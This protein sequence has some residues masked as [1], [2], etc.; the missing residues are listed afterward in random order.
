M[1]TSA[2]R[3]FV[4]WMAFA[5]GLSVASATPVYA[6][7]PN[8]S[9]AE[10]FA[11]SCALEQP[12]RTGFLL[13]TL[14]VPVRG[15]AARIAVTS[16]ALRGIE[17]LKASRAA[18][19]NQANSTSQKGWFER[20]WKWVVIPAAAVVATWLILEAWGCTGC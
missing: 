5:A 2:A 11:P 16:N 10:G 15:G 12:A 17:P 14:A 13:P 1:R 19:P 9:P 6:D 4:A 8:A 3:R 7:P 18:A 20:H